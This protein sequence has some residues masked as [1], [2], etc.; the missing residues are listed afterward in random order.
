MKKK[1]NQK[2]KSWN[3]VGWN[4]DLA[5]FLKRWYLPLRWLKRIPGVSKCKDP[6]LDRCRREEP[7][8]KKKICLIIFTVRGA[9]GRGG[10]EVRNLVRCYRKNVTIKCKN[11]YHYICSSCYC[12][13]HAKFG[14]SEMWFFWGKVWLVGKF[15][16][17]DGFLFA[18]MNGLDFEWCTESSVVWHTTGNISEPG[19]C[20]F[21]KL[22]MLLRTRLVRSL[23]SSSFIL[24]IERKEEPNSLLSL[25]QNE[26]G[27]DFIRLEKI[28]T[29]IYFI[30][31]LIE[32]FFSLFSMPVS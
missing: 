17:F 27:R 24:S 25:R 1:K 12:L 2:R 21:G 19:G 28:S 6:D 10:V 5:K 16:K 20:V 22:Q 14:N 3:T 23:S 31:L 32:T 29:P 11:N 7:E 8:T 9:K 15:K 26:N 30:Y 4:D 13:L 18:R